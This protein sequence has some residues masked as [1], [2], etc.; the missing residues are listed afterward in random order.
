MCLIISWYR[1]HGGQD[2]I[3]LSVSTMQTSALQDGTVTLSLI[4]V[5]SPGQGHALT[6]QALALT[7][8][9]TIMKI[10]HIPNPNP[11]G[12]HL[13]MQNTIQP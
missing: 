13:F 3:R 1:T 2:D 4:V 8:T 6:L 12:T 10:V 11:N 5:N 9:L 7:L